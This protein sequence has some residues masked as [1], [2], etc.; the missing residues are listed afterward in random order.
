ML[1]LPF[2][3]RRFYHAPP[4]PR[5]IVFSQARAR[6]A[7]SIPRG[8]T[9]FP[10]FPRLARPFADDRARLG[11][12]ESRCRETLLG[13]EEGKKR[14]SGLDR[15]KECEQIIRRDCLHVAARYQTRPRWLPTIAIYEIKFD[16]LRST[17]RYRCIR[18]RVELH[19]AT[20]ILSA[21]PGRDQRRTNYLFIYG[22]TAIVRFPPVIA[23]RNGRR[24]SLY[25]VAFANRAEKRPDY[26]FSR[27]PSFAFG[28]LANVAPAGYFAL[29][30]YRDDN[31]GTAEF[32]EIESAVSG[33]RK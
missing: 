20:A 7:S 28:P 8:R 10:E 31:A 5:Q 6:V 26:R 33:P 18:S 11:F 3:R 4:C 27:L 24:I 16:G 12:L 1:S 23:D 19:G 22:R 30:F 17:G 21:C 32:M 14:K 13:K 9:P 15:A 2:F 25:L 29:T